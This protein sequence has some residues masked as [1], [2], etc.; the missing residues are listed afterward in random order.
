VLG[1]L[2]DGLYSFPMNVKS[3][4]VVG[5]GIA[6]PTLAYWLRRRGFEPVL[7]ERAPHFREGGYMIDFWGV[8]FDVAAQMKLVPRIRE[9]GYIIDRIKFVN[10]RGKTTSEMGGDIFRRA[11][12]DRFIS[13]PRGD[14]A[15]AI[16]DNIAGEIEVIFGD[17]VTSIRE[18][19]A[20]VEVSFERTTPRRFDL[21]AG[22][23]GLHSTVRQIIFGP[24]ENFEKYLG[25]Y[26]ASFL[27]TNYPHREDRTYTSYAAPA[28]QIS[29]YA[30]RDDRV[31]FLFVFAREQTL[32]GH[33][34]R[35]DAIKILRD[36]FACDSWVELS[37]IMKRLDACSGLYFDSVSQIRMPAWSK[38]RTVLVGD[39]AYCPSLLAGEG[40][41]FAMAGAYILAG[42]LQH[43]GGDY[44]RACRMY[45]ER[46]R[47]FIER[48]QRSA[49]QFAASFA[50]R[51]RLGLRVRD[52][53]LRATSFR[54]VS[55]RLMHRFVT[56]R[57]V[58]PDYSS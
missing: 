37:E 16:F 46:F 19:A 21:V 41:A 13:L 56:D 48:K 28:R 5:A 30:L 15:K 23:D 1:N 36:T 2:A 55:D 10:E 43:A 42:E 52:L 25:Y 6:G 54:L 58:L 50:P 34:Q 27:T 44:L 17:S 38:G 20:G 8:G 32:A 12:G 49:E 45:E 11:L 35:I 22:C 51:T 57:F 7:V 53:V 33:L 9:V 24:E 3:V 39:A 29:R 40:A 4:L 26:S 47:P 18:E 14:L 31:A